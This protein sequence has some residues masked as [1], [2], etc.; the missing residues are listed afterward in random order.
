MTGIAFHETVACTLLIRSIYF[1]L[2]IIDENGGSTSGNNLTSLW[3]FKPERSRHR[4]SGRI[5]VM[6]TIALQGSLEQ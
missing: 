2:L 6:E 1:W 4:Q 5:Y 3:W